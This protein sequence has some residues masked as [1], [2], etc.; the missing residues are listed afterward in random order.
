MNNSESRELKPLDGINNSGVW[1]IWTIFGHE[2]V[3]LKCYKQ[4]RL[5]VDMN[6]SGSW[7]QASKFYE[8]LKVMVDMKESE[9]WVQGS[10]SY[11]QLKVVDDMKDTR[12]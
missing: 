3:S 9:S 1:M 7:A 2:T 5:I 4:H 6:D 8:Q 12:S 11:A 10:R